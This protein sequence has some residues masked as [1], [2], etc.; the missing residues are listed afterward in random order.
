MGELIIRWDLLTTGGVITAIPI[1]FFF[2]RVQRQRIAGL[3]VGAVQ[4]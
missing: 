1:V 3:T 4:G 2:M